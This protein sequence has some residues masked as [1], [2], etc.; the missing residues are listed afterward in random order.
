MEGIIFETGLWS[1][2]G[3]CERRGEVGELRQG[4]SLRSCF[5][6]HLQMEVVEMRMCKGI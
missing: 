3:A 1:A 6:G 4:T 2:I 5:F